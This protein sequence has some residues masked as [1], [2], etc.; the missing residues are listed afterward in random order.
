MLKPLLK[1]IRGVFV[2][3][4]RGHAVISSKQDTAFLAA[5]RGWRTKNLSAR[6]HA[7]FQSILQNPAIAESRTDF[8]CLG[9]I[10]SGLGER[11][12]RT[13]LEVG[14]GSGWNSHVL[15]M[16][17]PHG[18]RYF[19]LDLSHPSLVL[20]QHDFGLTNLAQGNACRLPFAAEAFDLV[21]SGGVL[22]HLEDYVSAIRESVRVSKGLVLFHTV[23]IRENGPTTF[24]RKKAYGEEV[25]ESVIREADLR[26]SLDKA[27][28]SILRSMPSVPYDLS[29][30]LGEPTRTQSY[31]CQK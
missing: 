5:N 7:V 31:L 17:L 22:M 30:L 3:D 12:P 13:V 1:K 2:G 19:G 27:G 9:E 14:C 24:L 16:V 28:V 11:A 26:A 15:S 23:L 29:F 20:G 21:I 8:R 10:L 18:S 6:Q 25:M 4:S